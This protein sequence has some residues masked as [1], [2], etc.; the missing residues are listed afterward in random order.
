MAT[1]CLWSPA[2]ILICLMD[3]A[4]DKM[5]PTSIKQ[6]TCPH[7]KPL[8]PTQQMS[9]H[10]P[11]TAPNDIF[12]K[13]LTVPCYH[14]SSTQQPFCICHQKWPNHPHPLGV[15]V[16]PDILNG[17]FE[18]PSHPVIQDT[19]NALKHCNS[20]NSLG[21]MRIQADDY[22]NIWHKSKE[23]TSS[24]SKYGLHFGHYIALIHDDD[25]TDFHTQMIDITLMTGYSPTRWCIGLNVMIPKKTGNYKVTDL[26]TLLLYDAE[27]NATHKWIR[28]I[29]MQRA[30][31]LKELAPEQYGSS[32]VD[33]AAIY[34]SLHM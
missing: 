33:H 24:C 12:G 1:P 25:L 10:H 31:T 14:H 34:Q 15:D 5:P 19:L 4:M 23:K 11:W 28:R 2:Y 22:R 16:A 7:L 20:D 13:H 9:V 26:W 8:T 30:E 21:P 3:N 6:P 32:W 27:F 18:Y 29:I 17:K